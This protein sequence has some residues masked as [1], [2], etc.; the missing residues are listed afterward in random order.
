MGAAAP[1]PSDSSNDGS[2]NGG[3]GGAGD[4]DDS[5]RET[6]E[7]RRLRLRV[8]RD[9]AADAGATDAEAGDSSG[10]GPGY[11]YGYAG[12]D[13]SGESGAHTVLLGTV[14]DPFVDPAIADEWDTLP[15]SNGTSGDAQMESFRAQG[16]AVNAWTH[17]MHRP[18]LLRRDPHPDPDP[19]PAPDPEAKPAP[20]HSGSG[21]KHRPQH[22]SKGKTKTKTK[23]KAKS[24][25]P[26]QKQ[27]SHHT[28][29]AEPGAPSKP[30][31]AAATASRAAKA[32]VDK[33]PQVSATQ[34][35]SSTSKSPSCTPSTTYV[36]PTASESEFIPS[37]P[38]FMRRLARRTSRDTKLM[39]FTHGAGGQRETAYSVCKYKQRDGQVNPDVRSLNSSDYMG[40]V[41][42]AGITNAL[43]WVLTRDADYS[44]VASTIIDT[45]FADNATGMNPNLNYGQ[46]VRGP[47]GNQ[48]GSFM[49]VVDLRGLT[50]VANAVQLLR[51]SN[52]PDWTLDRDRRLV[53]W[54]K[55]YLNWLQTSPIGKKSG[56]AAK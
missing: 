7:M 12:A 25:H 5:D 46:V 50:K 3:S 28:R 35:P 45:F 9:I 15:W 16:H 36:A 56:T 54:A 34:K 30:P 21:K 44:R 39:R 49:A 27:P 43:A 29:R 55:S 17:N 19:A 40:K 18:M 10:Q 14:E 4:S 23:T 1:V 48:L 33:G 53:A 6:T 51:Q 52:S 2:S 32:G 47:P 22:S 42:Q 31:P 24:K 41:T 26:K 11:G 38:P 13:E 37:F 20:A 8:R